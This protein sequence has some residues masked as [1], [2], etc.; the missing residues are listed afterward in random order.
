MRIKYFFLYLLYLSSIYLH[1]SLIRV[2]LSFFYISIYFSMY[3]HESLFNLAYLYTTLLYY[4][5][6][7]YAYLIHLL[8]LHFNTTSFIFNS[9]YIYLYL[10]L[11]PYFTTYIFLYIPQHWCNA[12]EYGMNNEITRLKWWNLTPNQI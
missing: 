9:F 4:P 1:H 8:S 10:N 6:L 12:Y 2:C 7:L 5:L 3:M 11:F